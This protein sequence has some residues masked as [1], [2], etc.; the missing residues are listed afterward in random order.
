MAQATDTA[1]V[2]DRYAG[3]LFDL[4]RERNQVAEVERGLDGFA[5]LVS[6]NAD[7]R[8]LVRSPVISTAEQRSAMEKLLPA[9]GL[10]GLT[11]DF[12]LLLAKNRRLFAIETIV[13]T[14]KKKAAQDRGEVEAQIVSAIP[15]TKE[16]QESLVD[17]LRTKL[18]KTPK[19]KTSVDKNL[20]GG[21]IVKVGSQMIDTSLRTKLKTLEHS[22]KEAV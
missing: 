6:E 4:A 12:L 20:L 7:L 2:A 13:T 3:A 9:F 14:Y 10:Q 17:T 18:G 22:M 16:Q 5:R 15:L 8:R 21:M 19:L 1:G 11:R